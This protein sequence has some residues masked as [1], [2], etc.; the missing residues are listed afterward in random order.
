MIRITQC[1]CTYR[2]ASLLHFK[3][4]VDL[5]D[6]EAFVRNTTQDYMNAKGQ[7][8]GGGR[9]PPRLDNKRPGRRLLTGAG[10]GWGRRSPAWP[11]AGG[12]GARRGWGDLPGG[13]P[14]A[15]LQTVYTPSERQSYCTSR[16]RDI[17]HDVR[18]GAERSW[19]AS[20][21]H[22]AAG[23]AVRRARDFVCKQSLPRPYW[24]RWLQR[25]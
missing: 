22:S 16:W 15:H 21:F 20:C 24:Y 3:M 1:T 11:G 23:G 8:S 10:R 6:E 19:L 5:P 9:R 14:G 13:A 17:G 7:G 18:E 25:N 2:S 12:G 4:F